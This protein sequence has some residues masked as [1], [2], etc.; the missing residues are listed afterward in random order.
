MD[1]LDDSVTDKKDDQRYPFPLPLSFECEDVHTFYLLDGFF[2]SVQCD[3]VLSG[4]H[5][6]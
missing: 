6:R 1:D 5:G 4:W 2:A 3:G